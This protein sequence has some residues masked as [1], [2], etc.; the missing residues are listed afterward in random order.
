MR[1]ERLPY[2]IYRIGT[3]RN[4]LRRRPDSGWSDTRSLIGILP[5]YEEALS[6]LERYTRIR[7]IFWF[8]L[9]GPSERSVLRVRPMGRKDAPLT[10]VFAT[11]SPARPNPLGSTVVRLL[12]VD[13]V[14]LYV[15]ALD[16][17]E[18]TPVVDIKPHSRN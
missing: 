18:G 7:V 10:G 16:A 5:Q 14:H 11:R 8:H 9:K 6:G 4:G 1:G 2:D 3:V 15:A 17:L 13:G 12:R